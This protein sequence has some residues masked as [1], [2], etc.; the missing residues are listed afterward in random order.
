M[1]RRVEPASRLRESMRANLSVAPRLTTTPPRLLLLPSNYM[2]N[3][4]SAA[5]R[6]RQ[7]KTRTIQNRRALTAVKSKLKA[8]R[9]DFGAGKVDKARADLPALV[10][11]L[12]R[13]VKTGRIHPNA[14]ARR[15]S[16]LAKMFAA[17]KA[18]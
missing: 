17:K 9:A 10:S 8:V 1:Q 16:R 12:D 13:A 4:K 7:I 3:T 15:K 11:E 14:A 5:K 2:A 18:A 6:A